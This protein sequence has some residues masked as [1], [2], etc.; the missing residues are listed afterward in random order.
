MFIDIVKDNTTFSYCY[1]VYGEGI[2]VREARLDAVRKLMPVETNIYLVDG[3]SYPLTNLP[4]NA[5]IFLQKN[6]TR[7][8]H[9]NVSLCDN[10]ISYLNVCAGWLSSIYPNA[11]FHVWSRTK[12]SE[13][14]VKMLRDVGCLVEHKRMP[15]EQAVAY[16]NS[17][18]LDYFD[19]G[20][21]VCM[22]DLENFTPSTNWFKSDVTYVAFISSYS[23]IDVQNYRNCVVYTVDS[24]LNNAADYAMG[25]YTGR[26]STWYVGNYSICSRD[27][28]ADTVDCF[29]RSINVESTRVRK[30]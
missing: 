14:V 1:T 6:T 9:M 4:E 25:F 26:M 30:C 18:L 12:A 10:V 16:R 20:S 8:T 21:S 3:E 23:A 2:N 29:L 17:S 24:A 13:L 28:S 27:K 15:R 5:W 22:V 19:I 7:K 11:K